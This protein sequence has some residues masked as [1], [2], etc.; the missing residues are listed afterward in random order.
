MAWGEMG[1][2][3]PSIVLIQGYFEALGES[4]LGVW[5]KACLPDG[6]R[7]SQYRRY[8]LEAGSGDDWEEILSEASQSSFFLAQKKVLVVTVRDGRK[9]SPGKNQAARIQAYA[10]Q[11]SPHTLLVVYLSLPPDRESWKALKKRGGRLESWAKLWDG[12][13]TAL[14]DL[15]RLTPRDV[16]G[17]V[18]RTLRLQEQDATPAALERMLE[19]RGDEFPDIL[20]QLP[21]LTWISSEPRHQVDQGDVD[22]L[23]TGMKTRSVWDLTNALDQGDISRYLQILGDLFLAGVEV[24]AL[25]ATLITHVQRMVLGSFLM[26][27]GA[28]VRQAAQLLRI[29]PF[30]SSEFSTQMSRMNP[31]RGRAILRLLYELDLA[32]KTQG[33]DRTRLEL[34]LFAVR[35]RDLVLN[36]RRPLASHRRS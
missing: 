31:E 9:L 22:R 23:L 30:L 20:L 15:D 28:S 18:R 35:W 19:L 14:V 16:G 2:S 7:D 12:P 6:R 32:C 13:E 3:L 4:L 5:A 10:A 36:V 24:V 27:G 1:A 34:E 25:S 33:E 26:E 11:P 8:H 17:W 21:K 29:P